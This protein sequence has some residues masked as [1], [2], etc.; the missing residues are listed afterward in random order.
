MAEEDTFIRRGRLVV[1]SRGEYSDYRYSGIFVALDD[2][3]RELM[4][5]IADE[6]RAAMRTENGDDGTDDFGADEKF[7]PALIKRG[8][9]LAVD[10]DEIHYGSYGRLELEF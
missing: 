6:C 8:L 4:T 3:S 5:E 9:L 1:F 2:I 7:I 10:Y